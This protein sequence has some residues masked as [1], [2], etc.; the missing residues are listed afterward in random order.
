M[1]RRTC[2]AWLM[3][4]TGTT[5]APDASASSCGPAAAPPVAAASQTTSD[6]AA[7]CCCARACEVPAAWGAAAAEGPGR[8]GPTEA[9]PAWRRLASPGRA[10]AWRSM[11][12]GV[13]S[14]R[15]GN[16]IQNVAFFSLQSADAHGL[17]GEASG[18]FAHLGA[19]STPAA[20]P[21]P[22][23]T[24]AAA[25]PP[26][27]AAAASDGDDHHRCCRPRAA[28]AELLRTAA[29]SCAHGRRQGLG[30]RAYTPAPHQHPRPQTSSRATTRMHARRWNSISP[31]A[32]KP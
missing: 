24:T 32:P 31:A 8:A 29:M 16:V 14:L 23:A 9:P 26:P 10:R 27:A 12:G 18:P 3:S 28:S 25:A 1:P 21:A 22:A 7:A 11:G 6:G 19:G 30:I 20:A 2:T 13:P 17:N 5:G 4:R 15:R